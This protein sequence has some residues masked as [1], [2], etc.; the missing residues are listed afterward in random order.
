M[1]DKA[2]LLG[3]T[4]EVLYGDMKKGEVTLEG[5]FTYMYVKSMHSSINDRISDLSTNLNEKLQKIEDALGK[6][7]GM[8]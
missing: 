7:D 5:L 6:I 8:C 1:T 3:Q 2:D 4:R